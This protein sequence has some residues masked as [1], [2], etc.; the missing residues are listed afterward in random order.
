MEAPTINTLSR[1]EAE[2]LIRLAI[3]AP[4]GHNT[5]PWKFSIRGH[6]IRIYPDFSRSLPVVD[7][8]GH[9]L[10]I[11]LGC[12]LENL[13]IAAQHHG[14]STKVEYFPPEESQD[15]LVVHLTPDNISADPELFQAIPERQ[16]T[17]AVYDGREIPSTDRQRLELASQQAGVQFRL[18]P[19]AQ[20]IEPIIEFVKEGN[21]RQFSD[22]AFVNELLAWVRFNQQ[23]VELL[24]DGLAGAVMGLPSI[25]RWLGT[26]MMKLLATPESQ[27]KQFE[28]LVRSSSALMLFIAEQDDKLHWVNV[29]RSFERV[30][31]TATVLNLK[32]AHINMP[33]EVL[34]V[35][36]QLQQYLG[37][38][39]AQPLLLLRLGY[40]QSMPRSPRRP[41]QEVL[42]PE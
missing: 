17:R 13:V 18:F 34:E 40:S 32:H 14:F 35:R 15:C 33:C 11:S 27:A 1:Q 42:Q 7:P 24:H 8:D 25:P 31:L 9:A 2:E 20:E 10:F 6:S 4:S 21:R 28:K 22:P 38:E 12:A 39:E 23:E 37:L 16:S 3:L 19:T 5:Q 29:G 36:T 30:A 26:I 41:L